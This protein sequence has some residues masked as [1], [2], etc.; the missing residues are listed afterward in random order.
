MKSARGYN[1][2]DGRVRGAAQDAGAAR[3]LQIR[4]SAAPGRARPVGIGLGCARSGSRRRPREGPE[5]ERR[6]TLLG[7]LLA[8]RSAHAAP[9]PVDDALEG[10][11][12][13]GHRVGDRGD[14]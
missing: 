4:G 13:P 10:V 11:G 5:R 7:V 9:R 1:G 14:G 2:F 8:P 3:A 12:A 6:R